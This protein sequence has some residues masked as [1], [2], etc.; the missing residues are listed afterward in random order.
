MEGRTTGRA[1]QKGSGG[2]RTVPGTSP[3]N[4]PRGHLSYLRS[5]N[6]SYEG[7]PAR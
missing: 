6:G 2:E 1:D 7:F 5:A 3:L 4:W